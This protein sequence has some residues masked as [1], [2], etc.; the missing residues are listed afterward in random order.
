MPLRLVQ[1]RTVW[2][3]T[4]F[5]WF[6]LLLLGCVPAV[7]W[8]FCGEG[9]LALTDRQPADVLVVEGWIGTEGIRAAYNEYVVGGYKSV[10]ATGGLTGE[11]WNAR[12]WN[13]ANEAAEQLIRLGV[14][15]DRLLVAPARN[16]E[17]Q[18]TFEMAVAARNS[19]GLAAIHSINV[20]TRGAHARRSR[21]VFE[22]VFGPEIPVGVISWKPPTFSDEPWWRSSD[23]AE[24]LIK[25]T[26]GYVFE[27]LANSGRGSNKSVQK[28]SS[29][30]MPQTDSHSGYR[31]P[32][33]RLDAPTGEEADGSIAGGSRS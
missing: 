19:V 16:T 24:D 5:G 28:S 13:Y 7:V 22:K 23:R 32:V 30:G 27:R 12:R 10:V 21:L 31:Q 17:A 29:V 9:I 1:R 2:L 15:Q 18:R 11:R 4:L 25:E 8:C 26:V 14:P 3:P 6:L 20:F 33:A